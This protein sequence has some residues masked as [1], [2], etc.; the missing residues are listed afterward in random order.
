[1]KAY[2]IRSGPLVEDTQG[3]QGIDNQLEAAMR[4]GDFVRA[5]NVPHCLDNCADYFG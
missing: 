5:A 4:F 1:V 2:C 3:H